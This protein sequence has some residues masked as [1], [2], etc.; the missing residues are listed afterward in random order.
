MAQRW[1]RFGL[2]GDTLNTDRDYQGVA[3]L[4]QRLLET[5]YRADRKHSMVIRWTHIFVDQFLANAD[6]LAQQTCTQLVNNGGNQINRI[7]GRIIRDAVKTTGEG[8]ECGTPTLSAH[9]AHRLACGAG[10]ILTYS[11]AI[12]GMTWNA[13]LNNLHKTVHGGSIFVVF[14]VEDRSR[15]WSV[16]GRQ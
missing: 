4:E 3:N 14:I 16:F 15:N 11:A 12:C 6:A 2:A 9:F 8:S 13:A 5:P 7:E 10:R 1:Q